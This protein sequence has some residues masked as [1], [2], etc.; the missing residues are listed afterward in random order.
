MG[1]AAGRI[2]RPP[3]IFFFA[4]KLVM[5]RFGRVVG[6]KKVSQAKGVP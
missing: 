3:L 1:R 4:D 2:Q 5:V 6:E